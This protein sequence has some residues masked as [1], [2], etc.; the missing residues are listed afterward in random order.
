MRAPSWNLHASSI[1][2][3]RCCGDASTR[4]SHSASTQPSP[5]D[6]FRLIQLIESDAVSFTISKYKMDQNQFE[7]NLILEKI[8]FKQLRPLAQLSVS[9]HR[10]IAVSRSFGEFPWPPMSIVLCPP[11]DGQHARVRAHK[12]KLYHLHFAFFPIFFSRSL[13]LFFFSRPKWTS[14]H[15]IRNK[16]VL[17]RFSPAF[18]LC[19][20]KLH[21][22]RHIYATFR[23]S[24]SNMIASST[25]SYGSSARRM[26][27]VSVRVYAARGNRINPFSARTA[28]TVVDFGRVNF[29]IPPGHTYKAAPSAKAADVLVCRR[30]QR[31]PHS[32]RACG[33]SW[34]KP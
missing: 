27:N 3:K 34:H 31:C 22:R 29:P 13:V 8:K 16:F 6:C 23:H 18:V 1:D 10:F 19:R 26:A 28:R 15:I 7:A 5:H 9:L 2:G 33:S 20:R 25:W 17:L 12:R 32:Q 4:R 24:S 14:L 11:T 30:P 21:V